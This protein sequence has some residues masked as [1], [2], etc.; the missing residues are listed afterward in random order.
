M[1]KRLRKYESLNIEVICSEVTISNKNWVIFS[2]YRPPDYS[3]LLAFFKELGKYLNQASENY[4]NFI[5]MGDFNIDIRQTS[6]ES[7]KLDEFC[8]LFSLTNII[9]SDTC[10]PKFHSSTIDL[11]L[12]NK[13]NFFQKTNAIETGFR[14]HHKLIC[15]FFKSCY[16]RLKPKIVYYRNYKKFNEANFLNDVKNCDFSLKTDD[17][18]ET[19]TFSPTLSLTS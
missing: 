11:F 17:P 14:D 4:D 19:T 7:H 18:N 3:N 1:C 9:K 8:S 6:P 10:F 13:P 2:I 15:N 5:E 12:T 16:D